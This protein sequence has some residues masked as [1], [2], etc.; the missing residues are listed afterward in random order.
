M[1]IEQGA[2]IDRIDYN[3]EMTLVN[4]QK[5]NDQLFEAKDRMEKG[6]AAKLIKMLFVFNLVLFFLVILKLRD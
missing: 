4:V 5:G 1:V 6:C 3:M 2:V